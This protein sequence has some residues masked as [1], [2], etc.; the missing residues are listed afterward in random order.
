MGKDIFKEQALMFYE[1]FKTDKKVTKDNYRDLTD[2]I[3]N[4]AKEDLKIDNFDVTFESLNKNSGGYAENHNVCININE[5][6]TFSLHKLINTLFHEIRHIYQQENPK[7]KEFDKPL[8]SPFHPKNVTEYTYIFAN[9]ENIGVDPFG[10]YVVSTEE[11]D[12]RNYAS[13]MTNKFLNELKNIA[14]NDK[15]NFY[16][17]VVIDLLL[18][19]SNKKTII[20]LDK[21]NN[22]FNELNRNQSLIGRNSYYFIQDTF[23]EFVLNEKNISSSNL[24]DNVSI[25]KIKTITDFYYDDKI[26]K[27]I[28]GKAYNSENP[29]ILSCSVNSIFAKTSEKTFSDC[30]KMFINNGN[31]LKEVQRYLNNWDKTLVKKEFDKLSMD[32][33]KEAIE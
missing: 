29:Y 3:I 8:D 18:F 33:E 9:E 11:V 17:K 32:T 16:I 26:E 14:N 20:E 24:S 1:I 15:N 4:I 13:K 6:K 12:A 23:K 30:V 28:L 19:L 10:L 2:I 5:A 21:F 31:S 7:L 25:I 27:L 22:A